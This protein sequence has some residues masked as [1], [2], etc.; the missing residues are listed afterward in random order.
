MAE[1]STENKIY[2]D[3]NEITIAQLQEAQND[4][5]KRIVEDK[6]N[7]GHYRTLTRMQG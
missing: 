5:A 3:G 4:P 7:P 6:N 1:N 2:L